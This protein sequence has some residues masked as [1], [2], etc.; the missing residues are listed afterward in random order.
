[1]ALLVPRLPQFF[2]VTCRK[3][4]VP[5]K[6][7]YMPDIGYVEAIW[8]MAYANQDSAVSDDYHGAVTDSQSEC[9]NDRSVN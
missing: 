8:S 9:Y 3:T 1:M 7:Y 2:N 6:I 5:G 4:R